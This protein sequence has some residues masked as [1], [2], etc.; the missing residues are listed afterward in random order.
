[1]N[2]KRLFA[3][4]LKS[5]DLYRIGIATHTYADTFCHQNFVG[6]KESFNDMEGLLKK[7]IPV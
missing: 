5:A 7:I 1:M 3:K 2:V 6:F 4:S